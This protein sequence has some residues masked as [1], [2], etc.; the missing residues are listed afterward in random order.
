MVKFMTKMFQFVIQ[1][2]D[3]YTHFDIPVVSLFNIVAPDGISLELFNTKR[4][5]IN[6]DIL[7]VIVNQHKSDPN[8]FIEIRPDGPNVFI[9]Q[10]EVCSRKRNFIKLNRKN[11]ILFI[12]HRIS[13]II[14]AL[15]I[16]KVFYTKKN[17]TT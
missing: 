12:L 1:L 4:A 5:P 9:R 10:S 8:L 11:C 6:F 3:T 13:K 16:V 2:C 15:I 14:C 7:P 17:V